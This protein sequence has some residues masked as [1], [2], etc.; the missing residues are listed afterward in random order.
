MSQ[1]IPGVL[2]HRRDRRAP[3]SPEKFLNEVQIVIGIVAHGDTNKGVDTFEKDYAPLCPNAE[4][5]YL[6]FIRQDQKL[7]MDSEFRHVSTLLERGRELGG[8]YITDFSREYCPNAI[9]FL[10]AY[11][12]ALGKKYKKCIS[13]LKEIACVN[14]SMNQAWQH[15]VMD[16]ADIEGVCGKETRKSNKH[17]FGEGAEHESSKGNRK[18]PF[19]EGHPTIGQAIS[20]ASAAA[21]N[22]K[23]PG[24]GISGAA[25]ASGP[26]RRTFA[27]GRSRRSVYAPSAQWSVACQAG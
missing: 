10:T 8:V 17:L 26:A 15:Q 19:Y 6:Y 3:K 25:G 18:T 1:I 22:R 4:I 20:A 5:F 23:V 12:M 24:F 16:F 13:Y 9:A 27:R 7:K 2:L 11:L 14:T 21:A